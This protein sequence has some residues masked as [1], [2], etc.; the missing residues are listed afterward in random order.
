MNRLQKKCFIA[1]AGTHL[2]AVVVLLCSGFVTSTP[3][4]DDSQVLDVIPANIIDAAFRS[5]SRTA[6]VP[7]PQPQPQPQIQP[8]QPP[9]PQPQPQPEPPKPA[10]PKPAE[11]TRQPDAVTPQEHADIPIE[12]PK[13]HRIDVDLKPVV[14]KS[15]EADDRQAR[16]AAEAEAQA[17]AQKAAQR[18]RDARLRAI[19]SAAN[20]IREK[21]SS[22][23]EV[24]LPGDSTQAYADYASVVKTVYTDAWNLPDSVANDD[25]TVKV[26]VTIANNGR[27]IDAHIIE[28]CGDAPVDASVQRALDRVRQLEPFPDGATDKER[29][30]TIYFQPKIK[31]MLG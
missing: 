28:H 9:P 31:R 23:M 30:Y 22:A 18:A 15:T 16:A 6:A 12:K 14:R 19:R 11:P 8:P 2:L 29:T 1:V 27:V 10:P 7:P 5:G 3:K 13:P 21:S 17:K 24:D 25:E 26:S 4:P 20:T